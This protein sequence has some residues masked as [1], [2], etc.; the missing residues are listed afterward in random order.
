MLLDTAISEVQQICGWRSDKVAEITRALAFS[1]TERE[2]PN[3]SYPWWLRKENATAIV[4]VVNQA[5]YNLPTDYIQ[6][7]DEREGNLFLYTTGTSG[8]VDPT[9]VRT[10]FLKKMSFEIAQQRYYGQW[11][12]TASSPSGAYSDQSGAAGPGAP[13]SYYLGQTFVLIYPRPDRVYNV[14][15]RYWGKDSAQVLGSENAWLREAPWVL[16]GDAASK[17]C[18]DLGNSQGLAVAQGILAKAEDNLF[19]A[20][21]HREEVGRR[22]AMGSRL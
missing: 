6:D 1:Q 12:Y 11:P 7:T 9:T 8:V 16:I 13:V 19:R 4:T 22:R 5:Q 20:I 10:I 18:A 15:W 2:K 17:I 3:R 21:V 14:R